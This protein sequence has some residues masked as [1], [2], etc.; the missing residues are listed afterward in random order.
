MVAHIVVPEGL[1]AEDNT[2]N[3]TFFLSDYFEAVLQRIIQ[4]VPA[5]EPVYI[6]PGNPFIHAASEEEYAAQYLQHQRPELQVNYP[7]NIRD[8]PYL[9]TFDNA[10]VLRKWL[11]QEGL[12]PLGEVILYCNTPHAVRSQILFELCEFQVKNVVRCRPK[13]RKRQMVSRLW[14]YNYP[15]VQIIYELIGLVYNLNRWVF[16]KLKG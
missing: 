5:T 13:Q 3:E 10:R 4:E 11:E 15:V 7:V 2:P 12:W 8:R 9:D 16:W 14:F 6:S 1:A